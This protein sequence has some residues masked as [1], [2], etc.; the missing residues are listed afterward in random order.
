MMRYAMSVGLS[1]AGDSLW[2]LLT[3]EKPLAQR[4]PA[5]VGWDL[6]RGMSAMDTIPLPELA[7]CYAHAMQITITYH[8]LVTGWLPTGCPTV[9]VDLRTRTRRL[10]N[11]HRFIELNASPDL[12]TVVAW[13]D[14]GAMVY[15]PEP[16][17]LGPVRTTCCRPGETPNRW[18]AFDRSGASILLHNRLYDRFMSAY[19]WLGPEQKDLPGVAAMSLDG[20]TAFVSGLPGYWKF[21]T[22]SG[23]LSERIIL[24]MYADR[25]ILHPDGRRLFV[26][27]VGWVGV[28]DLR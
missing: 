4:P 1:P 3:D 23:G 10:L 11:L 13:G 22:A 27:S 21:D 19:R 18:P 14:S 5:L 25:L 7:S 26:F 17:S 2:V 6:A 12:S 15:L 9:D 20:S 8:A 24:P 28:V 16:D